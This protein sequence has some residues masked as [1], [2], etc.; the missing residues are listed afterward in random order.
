MDPF[1]ESVYLNN[2]DSVRA[3]QREYF[4]LQK[5]IQNNGVSPED[6]ILRKF[7]LLQKYFSGVDA[8]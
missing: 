5:T 8:D 4:T 1:D 3:I 7:K 2:F 6:I